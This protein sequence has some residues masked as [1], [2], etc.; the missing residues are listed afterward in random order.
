MTIKAKIHLTEPIFLGPDDEVRGY[1]ITQTI[2][3]FGTLYTEDKGV[4]GC[5]LVDEHNYNRHNVGDEICLP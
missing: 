2:R 4:I 1:K 5:L 3:V